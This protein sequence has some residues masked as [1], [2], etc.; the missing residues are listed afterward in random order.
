M[1][2]PNNQA[3]PCDVLLEYIL[4]LSRDLAYI[5]AAAPINPTCVQLL[6]Q[7]YLI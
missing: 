1:S 5:G 7:L 2:S 4:T 6:H 3:M